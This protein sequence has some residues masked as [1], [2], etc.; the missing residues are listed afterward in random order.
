MIEWPMSRLVWGF[1]LSVLIALA[2][3]RANALTRDGVIGAIVTGTLIVGFGGWLWGWLLVAFFASSSA[4][5]HYRATEKAAVQAQF[6]KGERR[7]LFQVLANGGLGAILAV[8]AAITHASWLFPAYLGA[9]A[10]VNADTWATE[11]GVLSR[12]APWLITTGQ[13]VPPGTSGGV[14]PLGLGATLAGSLFIGIAALLG[15][16]ASTLF[17]TPMFF[18]AGRWT[19]W[20]TLGG[21]GGALIDSVLG[22]TVQAVY[23][24]DQCQVET[25]RVVHH[26][27]TPTRLIRGW[28]WLN[29]DW[30]NFLSSLAGGLIAMELA[31]WWR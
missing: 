24:C 26:C 27:G 3:Y 11:L 28:R 9:L 1:A 30:V 10:T 17:G 8:A 14:T 15:A 16:W 12:R 5:S 4:L 18:Q 22:A 6:A 31:I 2:A 21:V 29:N 23:Y 25:E 7:D 13:T 20:A 19:A